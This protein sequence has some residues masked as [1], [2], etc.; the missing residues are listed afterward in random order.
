MLKRVKGFLKRPRDYQVA[1]LREILRATYE[2]IFFWL[3]WP[4]KLPFGIWMLTWSDVIGWKL[5]RKEF[6]DSETRFVWEYLQPGM[7]VLD[8]GANIGYYTLVAAKKVGPKGRV[9]AFEPSIRERR[10]LKRNLGFNKFSHVKV[11]NF[12]IGEKNGSTDFYIVH[13]RETGCNSIK[14]PAVRDKVTKVTINTKRLETYYQQNNLGNVD[15]IKM[16]VEGAELSVLMSGEPVWSGENRPVLMAEIMDIRT[17]PWGYK[18]V[19]IFDFMAKRN[20]E[21]FAHAENGKLVPI[22]RKEDFHENLVAIPEEKIE[23]VKK[24]IIET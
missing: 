19:E 2:K 11:E 3:V 12:G 9:I 8:I 14:P 4:V 17:E 24:H 10:R 21:W 23:L 20:Y 6:E 1:V 7:T 18:G 13:G 16:D 22:N 15:L 5:R